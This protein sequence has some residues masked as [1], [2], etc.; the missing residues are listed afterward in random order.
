[1]KM[2]LSDD[3]TYSDRWV[4]LGDSFVTDCKKLFR[5]NNKKIITIPN[6]LTYENGISVDDIQN[7]QKEILFVGR[8]DENKRLPYI[9]D[10]WKKL[11]NDTQFADWKLTI[12]GDGIYLEQ[13]KYLSVSLHCERISFE[14]YQNPL[15]YYKRSSILV[16]TSANEGFPMVLVEGQQNGCVPIVM[17]SFPALHDIVIHDVNGLIAKNDDIPGFSSALKTLMSN[18]QYRLRLAL[19]GLE[20]CNRF[21]MVAVIQQWEN[22]FSELING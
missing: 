14:G 7:K 11:Q 12:V 20:T 3:F 22:L 13:I 17:D 6:P 5:R 4:L 19:K 21:S 15:E 10:A 2:Q 1:M 8:I 18:D 9:I 16:M